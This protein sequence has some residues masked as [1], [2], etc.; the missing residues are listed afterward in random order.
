M[1]NSGLESMLAADKYGDLSRMYHLFSRVPV[2]LGD[3]KAFISQYIITLGTDINKS[4]S[5][6]LKSKD[7]GGNIAIRW[8]TDVLALQ[9]KFDLILEHATNKDKSFQIV[10]NDAFE[11]FINEN[12]KSAE[13]IS[14]FI[15]ENLKKGLK[16]V[17]YNGRH[18]ILSLLSHSFLL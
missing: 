6:E 1:N 17:K 11:K 2:G 14:L 18:A 12:Q 5:N 7:K 3:M 16:G 10:F 9:D 8:V 13:F 4:I 15:D